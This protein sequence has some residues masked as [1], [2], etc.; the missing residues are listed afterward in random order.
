MDRA[1]EQPPNA[2]LLNPLQ[3]PS[4]EPG[5]PGLRSDTTSPALDPNH[6]QTLLDMSSTTPTIP[7]ETASAEQK[8][9]PV[10]SETKQNELR[11]RIL[12]IQ[13]T[14]GLTAMEKAKKI[15]ELMMQG[16][17]STK[18][19]HG[20]MNTVMPITAHQQHS[21]RTEQRAVP[22]YDENELAPSYFVGYLSVF[23][24]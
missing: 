1:T 10:M 2:P 20:T 15:Q 22:T 3:P 14:M 18:S 8:E 9:I 13:N 19:Q 6:L 23:P 21:E 5:S 7:S 4:L 16:W 24:C 17:T 12:E 11:Q